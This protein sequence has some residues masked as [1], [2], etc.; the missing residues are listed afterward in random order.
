MKLD[1]RQ[2]L[3][4]TTL[5]VGAS[6]VATPAFAQDAGQSTVP[7]QNQAVNPGAAPPTGPVEAQPTPTQAA[8]GEP[9][10]QPTDIIVTGSRIPQP[11][12]ESASPVSVVTN[13]D[14]KL[15]GVTRV[16]DVLAQLPSAAASQNSTLA[17]GATGTAEVSLRELGSKRTLTL[18]NGRRLTPGDPNSTTQAA[19][20]NIIPA[21]LLKRV[22]V[23]TGGASSVYG[24]DAVAGVVNFIIDTDFEGVRFDGQWSIYQHNNDNPSVIGGTVNSINDAKG[25]PYPTGSVS[26]GRS[27]DGTVT[28][29]A[30]F[31]DGHG[32]GLLS[33]A[34]TGSR[35]TLEATQPPRAR[36]RSAVTAAVMNRA[37]FMTAC[38]A[39]RGSRRVVGTPKR[40]PRVTPSS[41]RKG[42]N[43]DG[44]SRTCDLRSPKAAL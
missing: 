28:I 22:E 32:S 26:D 15:S 40:G 9:V 10:N 27:I 20:I 4:A 41:V 12:L 11:N 8:T 43:R 24:A 37:F 25:F 38:S 34:G 33:Q 23:L 18:V 7:D 42:E 21:S 30:G 16:E 3:L 36:T 13:E 39:A 29:G 19:D 5:L 1:Y 17:N 35:R 31:D 44:R 6:M 14:V 2:R